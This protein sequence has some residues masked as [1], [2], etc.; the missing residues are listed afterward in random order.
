MPRRSYY[1]VPD[2]PDPEF[3]L[4]QLN[5]PTSSS[6][7]IY[8][9]V[10][11]VNNPPYCGSTS[12]EFCQS[13]GW[14]SNHILAKLLTISD[15]TLTIRERNLIQRIILIINRIIGGISREENSITGRLAPASCAIRAITLDA[16]E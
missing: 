10:T 11:L 5:Y 12:V 16:I 7:P 3:Y 9:F 6:V 8:L 13:L 2:M 15:G 4:R 1:L 14:E